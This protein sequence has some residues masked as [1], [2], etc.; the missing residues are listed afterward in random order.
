MKVLNVYF[1]HT[2]PH[3]SCYLYLFPPLISSLPT[4]SNKV[5]EKINLKGKDRERWGNKILGQRRETIKNQQW[6][7]NTPETSSQRQT[8][9]TD[10]FSTKTHFNH[11]C[12]QHLVSYTWWYIVCYE[13][14]V[15]TTVTTLWHTLVHPHSRWNLKPNKGN[16]QTWWWFLVFTFKFSPLVQK[17]WRKLFMCLICL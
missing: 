4:R 1:C 13:E 15:P 5:G 7:P 6:T 9:L 17:Y 16:D 11:K 8:S 3:T 14:A 2:V 12:R 10:H